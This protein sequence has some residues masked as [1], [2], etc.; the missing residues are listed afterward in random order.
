MLKKINELCD[1]VMIPVIMLF[2]VA[3]GLMFFRFLGWVA[4]CIS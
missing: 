1:V 3:L 4:I 2:T